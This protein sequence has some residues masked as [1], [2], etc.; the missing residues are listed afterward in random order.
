M[1]LR[2]PLALAAA[3]ILAP[4]VAHASPANTTEF[5]ASVAHDDLDLTTNEG[6]SRLDERVRTWVRQMCQNGGRDSASV[7]LE[8]DCRVS[9]LAA[10]A[11]QVRVAIA[12]ARAESIRFAERAPSPTSPAATPGA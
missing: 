6:V 9:A 12:N 4:A 11:P 10:T 3:L 5:D 1:T 2:L 8:R 7:R